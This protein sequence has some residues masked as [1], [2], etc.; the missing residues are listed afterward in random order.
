MMPLRRP[1][2]RGAI[3]GRRRRGGFLHWSRS[4]VLVLILGV[5]VRQQ[6]HRVHRC[7]LLL[8]RI[9]VLREVG[10]G[11]D[12]LVVRL[13]VGGPS[14]EAVV[15]RDLRLLLRLGSHHAAHLRGPEEGGVGL[16]LPAVHS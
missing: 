1:G 16:L 3:D 6:P 5:V 4:L 12:G 2:P 8:Y 14:A 7:R 9:D 15:D 11:R 13:E 10:D